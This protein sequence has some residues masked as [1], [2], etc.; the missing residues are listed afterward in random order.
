MGFS[1]KARSL[2][3]KDNQILSKM[4][5]KTVPLFNSLYSG[6]KKEDAIPSPS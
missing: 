2:R 6:G 5:D 1:S 4:S 3:G